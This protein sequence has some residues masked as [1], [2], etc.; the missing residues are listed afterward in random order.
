MLLHSCP[1]T[2]HRFPL[3]ETRTSTPL[4]SGCSPS[5]RP[6]H[7]ITPAIAD[8]RFR[9][10]LSPRLHGVHSIPF[11]TENVNE[12]LTN[13]T[14]SALSHKKRIPVNPRFFIEARTGF[15][16]VVEVLQTCALPLGYRAILK[17]HSRI[18]NRLRRCAA[19]RSMIYCVNTLTFTPPVGLE[20]TTL[21]LT[22]ACSTD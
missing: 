14:L 13:T 2:V 6:R 9:A 17:E 11:F 20:P 15:E 4:A 7:V 12:N 3:R 18:R 16:P 22:A 5:A 19:R 1:D 21:R 8:C 10:P